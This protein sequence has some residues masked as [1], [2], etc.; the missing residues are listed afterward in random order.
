MKASGRAG[1][2]VSGPQAALG[3]PNQLLCRQPLASCLSGFLA[4]VRGCDFMG[5]LLSPGAGSQKRLSETRRPPSRLCDL[6]PV[7][8][9]LWARFLS[10]SWGESMRRKPYAPPGTHLSPVVSSVFSSHCGLGPST[11]CT[12]WRE[13]KKAGQN[14]SP[15]RPRTLQSHCGD[16]GSARWLL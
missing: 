16:W 5:G 4:N 12:H 14:F 3:W 2:P 7:P 15:G 10:C 8:S 13:D 9:P 1:P 6:R 11:P